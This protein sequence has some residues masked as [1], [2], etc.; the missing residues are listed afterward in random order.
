MI[1]EL[2]KRES[3]AHHRSANLEL[4]SE[5]SIIAYSAPKKQELLPFLPTFW[6][7]FHLKG[8]GVEWI[9]EGLPIP[10]YIHYT[11][12][13]YFVAWQIDGY[14]GTKRG[15]DH[16]NDTIARYLLTFSENEAKRLPWKP[17]VRDADHYFPKIRKL[18]DLNKLKSLS[19]K[20][21]APVRADSF[22]DYT[23][24]AIKLYVEDRI[25]EIGMIE[26]PFL[27]D[28]ALG[29]FIEKERST[30]RAKC[31][32]IWNWY[33]QRDWQLPNLYTRKFTD[34]ELRMSREDHIKKVN[35]T[36]KAKTQAQ[37]KSVL[38]DMFVQDEIRTKTGKPKATAIAKILDMDYRTVSQHLKS[39][40]LI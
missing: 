29:Q 19:K 24:W 4:R 27:E 1:G 3:K 18:R 28:W 34:E 11:D 37:I 15:I 31:R 14:F 10:N 36:R 12:D 33:D 21:H 5:E 26:Y 22:E 7:H 17:D 39:M 9:D 8:T 16:V 30:V 2:I 40:D 25:R 35:A 23:F 20:I 32:S 38:E 6:L 13:G